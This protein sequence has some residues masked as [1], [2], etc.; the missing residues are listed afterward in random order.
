MISGNSGDG[1]Q[2]EGASAGNIV[3]V[4][5]TN[6]QGHGVRIGDLSFAQFKH[7]GAFINSNS[8]LPN[9]LCDSAYSATRG[10]KPTATDTNF[11]AE[12]QPLP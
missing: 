10:V 6:N 4:T 9:I 12:I 5:I 11:P 3:G 2:L 7:G 1:V 8:T